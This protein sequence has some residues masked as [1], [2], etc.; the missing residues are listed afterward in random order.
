VM[1]DG[2]DVGLEI[3]KG[4]LFSSF[5]D[6]ALFLASFRQHNQPKKPPYPGVSVVRVPVPCGI[7]TLLTSVY[8]FIPR[9][10]SLM[11]ETAWNELHYD[12]Y[13]LL[14]T[15]FHCSHLAGVSKKD[16][17]IDLSLIR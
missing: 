1:G 8:V 7:Q 9:C 6:C 12:R 16:V 17:E 2:W 13:K 3:G 15:P 14:L 10:V 4:L 11:V 5:G